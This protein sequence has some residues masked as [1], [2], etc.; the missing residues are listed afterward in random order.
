[1]NVYLNLTFCE[2]ILWII[3]I[4]MSILLVDFLRFLGTFQFVYFTL[5]C[6]WL[7]TCY[8][9]IHLCILPC[10]VSD[11]LLTCYVL[12]RLCYASVILTAVPDAEVTLVHVSALAVVILYIPRILPPKRLIRNIITHTIF[13]SS[14]VCCKCRTEAIE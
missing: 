1:M 14:N 11:W 7:T 6:D 4:I 10:Y 12:V 2:Y 13:L 5:L 9:L 3:I 8:V